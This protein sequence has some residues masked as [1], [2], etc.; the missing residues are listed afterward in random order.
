MANV[1]KFT[2]ATTGH[3]CAHYER[4]KGDDGEY[5]RFGNQN[6]NVSKTPLNYNLAPD[7]DG[8]Q[9]GFIRQRTSEVKCLRRDDV[10]V[11]CSWVITK[12]KDYQGDES[13][14]FRACYAFLSER[15]GEKNVIS[16]FV[17]MDEVTPH[18]H[19]AFVPVVVGKDGKEKVSAKV[20]LTKVELQRF[21]PELQRALERALSQKVPVLNGATAGGN[22]TVAEMKAE[23]KKNDINAEASSMRFKAQELRGEV[24][25]L[26]SEK[27]RILGEIEALKAQQARQLTS[28]E[29]AEAKS[30]LK[31]GP[32]G[33]MWGV[34]PEDIEAALR[35]AQRVDTVAA[36]AGQKIRDAEKSASTATKEATQSKARETHALE[37]VS[38]MKK[39]LQSMSI[40]ASDELKRQLER[41]LADRDPLPSAD[42]P[43]RR[44]T[45]A[46]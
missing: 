10:N 6:I 43:P 36:V 38:R 8:G 34:R 22:R 25:V 21:H 4:A 30:K 26:K 33:L 27:N 7:H 1:Q 32:L 20:L 16:A 44:S 12:P 29:A 45:P 39:R 14:F 40:S 28:Q 41:V 9:V 46:L 18:M 2:K 3:L 23:E 15:Y 35:T 31:K 13:A 19:F 17:H 5:I 42:T 37:L 11:M 24:K